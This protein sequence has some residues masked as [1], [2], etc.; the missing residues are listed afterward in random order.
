MRSF[1]IFAQYH[2]FWVHHVSLSKHDT[3][4]ILIGLWPGWSFVCGFQWIVAWKFS[5]YRREGFNPTM[6]MLPSDVGRPRFLNAARPYFPN[7]IFAGTYSVDFMTTSAGGQSP[8]HNID[9]LD[10]PLSS[11]LSLSTPYIVVTHNANNSG[12]VVPLLPFR[13]CC[14]RCFTNTAKPHSLDR[15]IAVLAFVPCSAKS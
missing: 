4:A 7:A 14:H 10:E 8:F 3:S 12:V 2:C 13:R 9:L 1:T 5:G 15:K 11:F 6:L